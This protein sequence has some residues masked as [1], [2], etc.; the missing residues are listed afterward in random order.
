MQ[1]Y[2]AQHQE[3]LG[4]PLTDA[5]RTQLKSVAGSLSWVSRQCRPDLAYR[6]SRIQSS[7]SKG[8]V[9]DLKEA[10][11]TVECALRTHDVGLTFKCNVLDWDKLTCLVVT[12]ASHANESEEMIVN[13]AVSI[14]AHRSQGAKMLR[15]LG[16]MATRVIFTL[17]PGAPAW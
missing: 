12:D 3:D 10:N 2:D 15:K 4:D 9:S 8:T 14:E 5:D 11:K 6:V 7:A 16:G 13:G 1:R 17:S